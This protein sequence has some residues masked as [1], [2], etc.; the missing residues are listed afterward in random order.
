MSEERAAFVR[1]HHR[2]VEFLSREAH[3]CGLR[4]ADTIHI[5]GAEY[6]VSVESVGRVMRTGQ[7]QRVTMAAPI[8]K[9]L[10]FFDWYSKEGA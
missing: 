2:A 3:R 8:P 7:R 1:E 4:I 5:D 9:L 6:T 10:R